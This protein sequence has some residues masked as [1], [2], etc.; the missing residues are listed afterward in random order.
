MGKFGGRE[1]NY[2][3]DLDLIFLYE[4]DGLTMPGAALAARQRR[5]T[6]SISSASWR[7]GSSRW[8]AS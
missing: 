4:A 7:S 6:T 1:L 8:P 2:Y 5:L 3:S